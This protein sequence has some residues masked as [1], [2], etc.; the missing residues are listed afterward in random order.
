MSFAEHQENKTFGLVYTL[1]LKRNSGNGAKKELVIQMRQNF[2]YELV[3]DL[4][5][6]TPKK[7]QQ[8]VLSEVNVSRA[9]A[10]CTKLKDVF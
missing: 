7:T 9:P 3:N 2:L 4:S 8:R 5:Y 10:E 1:F 6:H